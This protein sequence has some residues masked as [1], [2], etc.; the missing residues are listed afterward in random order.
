MEEKTMLFPLNDQKGKQ[1]LR[2]LSQVY[3]KN[4]QAN[5][6]TPMFFFFKQA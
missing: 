6:I 5:E 3:P 1:N 4:T 2:K